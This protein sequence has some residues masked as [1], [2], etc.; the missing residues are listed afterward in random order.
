MK[1]LIISDREN[2]RKR[3]R[4]AAESFKL[5]ISEVD[6][7][8]DALEEVKKG[9]H[10]IILSDVLDPG[11]PKIIR[12][13]LRA[14]PEVRFITVTGKMAN[15]WLVRTLSQGAFDYVDLL[16]P[17]NPR[18]AMRKAIASAVADLKSKEAPDERTDRR[19]PDR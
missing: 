1:V 17:W 18:D 8:E 6:N 9:E 19:R 7:L 12:V 2:L 5:K 3:L 11:S 16:A 10:E 4:V 15:W 13:A 14:N